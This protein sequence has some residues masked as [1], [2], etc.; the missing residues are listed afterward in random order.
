MRCLTHDGVFLGSLFSG[1]TLYELRCSLQ[2]A[3]TERLGG[4]SP[5]VSPFVEPVDVGSLLSRSGFNLL[6]VDN[7][8]IIVKYPSMFKLIDDLKL[9]GESN[10]AWNRRLHLHRES[11]L[12]AAA[13]YQEFYGDENGHILA[14]FQITNFIGWK[15]HE[16]QPKPAARGSATVS[17]KDI[18]NVDKMKGQLESIRNKDKNS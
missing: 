2:L 9:M 1:Q 7:D 17:F 6:T 5:H 18:G 16:S 8:E 12:A 15:P 14:T 4:F 3:E 10:A 11:L 13:I